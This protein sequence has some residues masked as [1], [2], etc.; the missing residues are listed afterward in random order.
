V[1]RLAGFEPTTLCLE[2]RC[3]IQLSYRRSLADI[4]H[5]APVAQ[6]GDSLPARARNNLA[7]RRAAIRNTPRVQVIQTKHGLRLSQ[8][9][10]VISELR[11]SPGPTHSVF[12]V[13]A[14]LLGLRPTGHVG[15][16][17]F[18]GGGMLAPLQA[19]K[20]KTPLAT[21]DLDRASYD[22]F[23]R[24]CPEWMR[25]VRWQQA[26]AAVWLRRQKSKFDLLLDDLSVPNHDDVIKPD[27][28]WQVLPGLMRR[29]LKGNGIAIFNLVSPPPEGWQ[30][31]VEKITREFRNVQAIHLDEFENR[32]LIAGNKL[33]A[34]RSLSRQLRQW[35]RQIQSRQAERIRVQ[36][37]RAITD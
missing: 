34:P 18:A 26:D 11:T 20:W 19:L 17:G 1:V 9:G 33:P 10:V 23:C 8:H 25:L 32:I 5:P 15:V 13:L 7:D 22:L 30:Y 3:S 21:V 24:H 14:A 12:D 4:K 29:R 37:L 31:G 35:L 36:S 27:L 6:A 2:G 16:L 28:S